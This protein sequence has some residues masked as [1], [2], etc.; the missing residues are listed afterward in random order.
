M[1][2]NSI[3]HVLS[4]DANFVVRLPCR[5]GVGRA[6]GMGWILLCLQWFFSSIVFG[7]CWLIAGVFLDWRQVRWRDVWRG[8]DVVVVAV[9]WQLNGVSGAL[10]G[11]LGQGGWC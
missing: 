11:G 6:S 3:L 5:A 7:F 8:V 9:V 1:N 10:V 4:T 2:E